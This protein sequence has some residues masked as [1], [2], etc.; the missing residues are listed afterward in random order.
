MN[1]ELFKGHINYLRT[2][3]TS[4]QVPLIQLNSSREYTY[5]LRICQRN[6]HLKIYIFFINP[7]KYYLPIWKD[8]STL[9]K[10]HA[11]LTYKQIEKNIANTLFSSLQLCCCFTAGLKSSLNLLVEINQQQRTPV[12]LVQFLQKPKANNKSVTLRLAPPAYNNASKKFLE[13]RCDIFRLILQVSF[14]VSLGPR[15]SAC[16]L[17]SKKL[18]P[19]KLSNDTSF[20]IDS[21][22]ICTRLL[23]NQK[24]HSTHCSRSTTCRG[25]QLCDTLT[26]VP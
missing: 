20:R 19:A 1:R 6:K 5:N 13:Q 24:A 8:E 14:A 7:G 17:R 16:V 9:L 10:I 12:F 25:I 18:L 11:Q 2:N 3:Q 26:L 21:I 22:L 15:R 23:V 4:S